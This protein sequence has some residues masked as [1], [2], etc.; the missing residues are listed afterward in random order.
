MLLWGT[1]GGA[2]TRVAGRLGGALALM[3]SAACAATGEEG[4]SLTVTASEAYDTDRGEVV[5]GLDPVDLPA[6][7]GHH[8]V[9]QP[10]AR[11]TVVPVGGWLHGYAVELVD[12]DGRPVPRTVLHHVNILRADRRELF[13]PIMQRVGASGSETADVRL[14]RILGYPIEQGDSLIVIAEFHNPTPVSYDGVHLR[15]RMPHTQPGDWPTPVRV[16]PFYMDV[17]PPAAPHGFDLP[18]GR[19][20]ASWEARPAV[21]GRIL[22]MGGHLHTYAVELRL[23]DVTA[24]TVVWRSQPILDEAGE[25]AGMPQSR[26]WWRLGL[27][28][29]DDHVYRLTAVYD[30]PTGARIPE[31]GMGALGGI[32]VP[33]DDATWPAVD[34]SDGVYVEDY[35]RR[36]ATRGGRSTEAGAHGGHRGH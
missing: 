36:V 26:L 25:L 27:P 32:I 1:A 5:L 22:G 19:S 30:N 6:H 13:S 31:G 8:A 3:V 16:Y 11:A 29:H 35:M 15:V 9:D 28:V 33:A 23:E 2:R 4:R 14:P 12:A 34:R 10:V 20:E 18:A 21:S 17:T 24:G 7:T